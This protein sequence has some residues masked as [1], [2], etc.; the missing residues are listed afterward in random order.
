MERP[1]VLRRKSRDEEVKRVV[2]SG[3]NI[4]NLPTSLELL[5]RGYPQVIVDSFEGPDYP[6][7]FTRLGERAIEAANMT[8]HEQPDGSIIFLR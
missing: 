3:R 7:A 6:C 5:S 1:N 8:I 4:L 2:Q